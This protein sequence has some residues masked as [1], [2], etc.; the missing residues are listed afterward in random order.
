M[1]Y[2]QCP[3][4]WILGEERKAW[5]REGIGSRDEG[6][7]QPNDVQAQY[8]VVSLVLW[9][10]LTQ[11]RELFRVPDVHGQGS[12]SQREVIRKVKEAAGSAPGVSPLARPLMKQD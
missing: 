8:G 2:S 5:D 9:S 3:L 4:T 11:N 10:F 12:V 1:V 6:E 7:D